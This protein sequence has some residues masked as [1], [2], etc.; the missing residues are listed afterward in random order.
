MTIPE[1]GSAPAE[2]GYPFHPWM[3]GKVTIAKALESDSMS[4]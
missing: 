4:Q 2:E 1:S 3:Q